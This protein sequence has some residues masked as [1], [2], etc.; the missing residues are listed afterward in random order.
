MKSWLGRTAQHP[1]VRIAC[2]VRRSESGERKSKTSVAVPYCRSGKAWIDKDRLGYA[3]REDGR[4]S[5]SYDSYEEE[6]VL[7]SLGTVAR[8]ISTIKLS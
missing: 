2:G 6:E 4:V 8:K 7:N 5:E 1:G 3:V